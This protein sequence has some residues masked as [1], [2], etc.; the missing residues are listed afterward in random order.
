[1]L[2]E[3]RILIPEIVSKLQGAGLTGKVGGHAHVC[4]PHSGRQADK[5]GE[6]R[7]RGNSRWSSGAETSRFQRIGWGA[8]AC[9][10]AGHRQADRPGD[11]RQRGDFRKKML[12]E[13]RIL[14]PE[15]VS[16]QQGA[17]L[18]GQ[19]AGDGDRSSLSCKSLPNFCGPD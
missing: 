19:D 9:L 11:A 4:L 13:Y 12:I 15:I 18:W 1:M 16:K 3:Y 14:I 8:R 10:S 17:M 7:Q 6:E 5:S 2:I